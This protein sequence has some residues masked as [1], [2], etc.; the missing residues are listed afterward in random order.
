MKIQFFSHTSHTS[1]T[2]HSQPRV[3][4]PFLQKALFGNTGRDERQNLHGKGHDRD[5]QEH[6]GTIYS[7]YNQDVETE[8]PGNLLLIKLQLPSGRAGLEPRPV[9][10][11]CSL[12]LFCGGN[13]SGTGR[14]CSETEDGKPSLVGSSSF[15][16]GTDGAGWQRTMR[17]PVRLERQ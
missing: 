5:L 1:C 14:V 8:A 12:R 11:S 9:L 4:F 16:K 10:I 6:G 2:P 15:D 3:T 13:E 17:E 7:C